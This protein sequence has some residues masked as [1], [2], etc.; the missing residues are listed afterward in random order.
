MLD[1]LFAL[2]IGINNYSPKSELT[3]LRGSVADVEA[4]KGYLRETLH[5]PAENITTLLNTQAT[6]VNII[7]GIQNLA[8]NTEIPPGSPILIYFAGHGSE[9]DAPKSWGPRGT[10]VQLIIPYDFHV[11]K[12]GVGLEGMVRAIPNR[13]MSALLEDLAQAKGD[14][15]IVILDSCYAGAGTQRGR[16]RSIQVDERIDKDLDREI[17]SAMEEKKKAV[18]VER[19]GIST[20]FE[21]YGDASHVLMAACAPDETAKEIN[22][23]G[24]FT[25]AL[26]KTITTFG[27][28]NMTYDSLI[29][30]LP[31]L[32]GTHTNGSFYEVETKGHEYVLRAGSIHGVTRG[33]EFSI[34]TSVDTTSDQIGTVIARTVYSITSFVE[35]P[36]GPPDNL[37][38]TFFAIQT[39]FLK[40]KTLRLH[41]NDDKELKNLCR[42]LKVEVA[43]NPNWYTLVERA[44]ANF[45]LKLHQDTVSFAFVNCEI[46]ALGL[47]QLPF[48][49]SLKEEATIIGVVRAAS[50]FIRY[51]DSQTPEAEETESESTIT[52]ATETEA[53]ATGAT[54]TGEKDIEAT[55]IGAKE[56]EAMETGAK[57][58]GSTETADPNSGKQTEEPVTVCI[59]KLRRAGLNSWSPLTPVNQGEE[60]NWEKRVNLIGGHDRYGLKIKNNTNKSLYPYLFFFNCNDL[61]IQ[62]WYMSPT[63][64]GTDQ[65]APLRP[66]GTME[67]GYNGGEGRPWRHIIEP[68]KAIAGG[69]IIR[70]AED[71]QI[72]FFK[73]ILTTQPFDFSFLKQ[74]TPFNGVPKVLGELIELDMQTSVLLTVVTRK[75]DVSTS[76]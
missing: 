60:L 52:G 24:S 63:T 40:P 5:V 8:N 25:K 19:V 46:E 74:E 62:Q 36:G 76:G 22:G 33:S 47:K 7:K 66:K 6:R 35:F 64:N 45:E 50:V 23:R 37:P 69:S 16:G 68:A 17:W 41:I 49:I 39:T 26:L 1:N 3:P 65:N 58:I 53:K 2:L 51:Y 72:D 34:H 48:R 43:S 61:S 31:P 67:I 20:G 14:N 55:E 56:T 28:E 32:L 27:I 57:E 21:Y 38:S 70:D 10:K 12:K 71:M 15:I 59:M 13:T 29:K 44:N 9:A 18:Q 30:R 54:E 4:V 42:R 11:F 73:L 75:G